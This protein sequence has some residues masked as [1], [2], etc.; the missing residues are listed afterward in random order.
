MGG[1]AIGG[2]DQDGVL[3]AVEVDQLGVGQGIRHKAVVPR[4][5]VPAFVE[6]MQEMRHGGRSRQ[7]RLA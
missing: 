5:S 3:Q 7:G 6:I 4:G 1:D 2:L